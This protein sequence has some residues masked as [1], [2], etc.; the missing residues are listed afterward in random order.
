MVVVRVRR[1][2]VVRVVMP[3][4]GVRVV[5]SGRRVWWVPRVPGVMVLMVL[6]GGIAILRG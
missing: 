3:V 6:M 5:L 2:V 4:R 1:V